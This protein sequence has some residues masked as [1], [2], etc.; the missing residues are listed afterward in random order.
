[1]QYA[2]PYGNTNSVTTVARCDYAGNG[3]DVYSDM[4]GPIVNGTRLNT[5]I[6]GCGPMS[7]TEL[8]NP[9]G[10]KTSLA[11]TGLA[12]IAGASNG[13]FYPGSEVR[14]SDISDGASNTYL[15]GE[16]YL[17]TDAYASGWDYGDNECAF[18][19]D[20]GD[21]VRWTTLGYTPR[22]D[23]P[24]PDTSGYTLYWYFFGSA[25]ANGFNMAFC[26]GAV[27]CMSYS[28]D[29]E[30]HRCLGNRKDGRVIDAKKL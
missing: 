7:A 25:H 1:L 22:Q 28:I 15:L 21:I 20:N 16:K 5:G 19:G 26:D 29:A 9:P 13:I 11:R 8:E 14:L 4:S 3:G 23:S 24:Y 30:V 17:A 6:P 27:S 18:I 2:T 10:Q 12:T